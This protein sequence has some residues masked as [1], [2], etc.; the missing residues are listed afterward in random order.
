M[1]VTGPEES[2][3][4]FLIVD[5]C[6]AYNKM[7]LLQLNNYLLQAKLRKLSKLQTYVGV[8]NLFC[9]SC[10]GFTGC[11]VWGEVGEGWVRSTIFYDYVNIQLL[12]NTKLAKVQNNCCSDVEVELY[13]E[14]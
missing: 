9:D 13:M 2:T 5:W 14:R 10:N 11:L 3:L 1:L 7:L 12:Q 4:H 8:S 6:T